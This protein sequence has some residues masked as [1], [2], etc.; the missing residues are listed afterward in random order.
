MHELDGQIVFKI[1]LQPDTEG[2]LNA[3]TIIDVQ[4]MNGPSGT[5]DPKRLAFLDEFRSFANIIAECLTRYIVKNRKYGNS[6]KTDPLGVRG[7]FSHISAKFYRMLQTIWEDWNTV[8]D[9]NKGPMHR[10]LISELIRDSLVYHCMLETLATE[11]SYPPD[12]KLLRDQVYD[13]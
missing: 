4:Y 12:P 11:K 13:G 1:T 10:A 7:I 5:V 2:N 3:N 8:Y 9:Q 6:W